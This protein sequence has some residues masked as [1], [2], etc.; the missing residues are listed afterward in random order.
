[1]KKQFLSLLVLFITLILVSC[2]PKTALQ[3][4]LSYP[5]NTVSKDKRGKP[6]LEGLCTKK[7]MQQEPFQE[8]YDKF[9]DGYDPGKYSTKELK[10][11]LNR[12]DIHVKVFMGTWCG[13]SKRNV[14]KF[15]RVMEEVKFDEHRVTLINMKNGKKTNEQFEKDLNI[16]RVPT[17][18]VY[19]GKE[20]IGRIVEHPV[21]SIE[22]DL[23]KII[24]QKPYTHHYALVTK[25]NELIKEK[26]AHYVHKNAATF[27]EELKPLKRRDSELNTYGYV[28]QSRGQKDEA[29]AAFKLNTL[30]FPKAAN[31]Y[32]SLGETYA[33]F[34]KTKLAIENYEKVLEIN[35]CDDHAEK[36]LQKIKEET[37]R[38]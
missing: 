24:N 32:D 5:I 29:L 27:V 14:P 31:T 4:N 30:L 11:A 6:M 12:N 23:L 38:K 37:S 3:T 28:I 18:I 17:F 20:E 36:M 33:A 34:G 2:S 25:V 35:P 9:H 22:Q 10:S 8:W 7:G 13:D 1:M 15:Y 16:H 21:Q 19:R 26:G